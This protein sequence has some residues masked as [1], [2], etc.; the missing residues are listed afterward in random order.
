M[1]N[2]FKNGTNVFQNNGNI[3][4]VGT[5]PVF[6][7]TAVP[8]FTGGAAISFDSITNDRVFV[9]GGGLGRLYVYTLSTG[10]T[11]YINTGVGNCF[12]VFFDKQRNKIYV[13]VYNYG[14]QVY[15]ASTLSPSSSAIAT[16]TGIPTAYDVCVDPVAT[17]NRMFVLSQGDGNSIYGSLYVLNAT[18]YAIINTIT[19]GNVFGYFSRCDPDASANRIFLGV[20]SKI[21]IYDLTTFSLLTSI[22]RLGISMSFDTTSANN[23]FGVGN[24]ILNKSTLGV[25]TSV[26]VS[27]AYGVEFDALVNSRIFITDQ[28]SLIIATQI[29]V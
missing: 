16:V 6:S 5:T 19:V 2:L 15:D 17:N 18:T 26:P 4:R 1:A 25:S 27:Q 23:R 20:G 11:Y 8:G 12:G 14:F 13:S 22:N 3:F 24:Y 28:S 29:A 10:N 21:N 7:I 9:A